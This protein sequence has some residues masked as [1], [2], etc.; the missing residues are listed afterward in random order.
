MKR[1]GC[2]FIFVLTT[3]LDPTIQGPVRTTTNEDDG[4]TEACATLGPFLASL[5]DTMTEMN[6]E[7]CTNV[8]IMD[9]CLT[10]AVALLKKSCIKDEGKN[11]DKQCVVELYQVAISCCCDCLSIP[12]PDCFRA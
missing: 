10:P 1:L 7:R 12:N 11:L 6:R 5:E 3:F 2:V 4:A 9:Q 8:E